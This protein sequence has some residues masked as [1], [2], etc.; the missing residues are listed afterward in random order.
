MYKNK[1][2]QGCLLLA[3][4]L[5]VLRSSSCKK[6]E[7]DTQQSESKTQLLT[8]ANWKIVK[9][10]ARS[11]PA[12]AWSDATFL[13]DACEK[14]N[15]QVYRTNATFELNEG[16]T[17]CDIADPQIVSTGTWLFLNG[18]TQLKMTETGAVVSDT[19]AVEQLDNSAL[20]LSG[21][22]DFGGSTVYT[23]LTFGH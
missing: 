3:F 9:A 13:L 4:S 17:K 16:A 21:K 2:L 14:D 23:R 12:A 10:E 7:D 1:F 19:V 22:G 8:K 5:V 18:E 6:D 15:I 20:I 11:S